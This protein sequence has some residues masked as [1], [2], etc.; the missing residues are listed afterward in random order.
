MQR[1]TR[2]RSRYFRDQ[3]ILVNFFSNT[4]QVNAAFYQVI[5]T[6]AY[7]KV[8]VIFQYISFRDYLM[9]MYIEFVAKNSFD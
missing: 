4:I 8:G 9:L 1:N 5:E 2:Y 7:T 3:A 6:D